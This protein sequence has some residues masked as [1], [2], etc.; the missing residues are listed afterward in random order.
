MSTKRDE[1][2]GDVFLTW[3]N[4]GKL[5]MIMDLRKK[6]PDAFKLAV[7]YVG[8]Q[9]WNGLILSSVA[10]NAEIAALLIEN[11][12]DIHVTNEDGLT[13]LIAASQEGHPKVVTM[14]ISREANVEAAA[15]NGWTALI[16]AS[17]QGHSEVVSILLRNGANAYVVDK[18]GKTALDLAIQNGHSDIVSM[19]S[20]HVVGG[21]SSAGHSM[22]MVKVQ[23]AKSLKKCEVCGKE[24]TSMFK[25]VCLAVSYW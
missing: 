9:G 4:C 2:Q 11:G 5:E 6:K 23:K 13:A 1:V 16:L 10:G 12:A 15:M 17:G 7:Q 8:I 21:G 3:C 19:L 14:L 22:A 18:F 24:S 20:S 25:C